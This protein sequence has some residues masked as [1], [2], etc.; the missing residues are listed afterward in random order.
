MEVRGDHRI[1]IKGLDNYTVEEDEGLFVLDS[2]SDGIVNRN[3]YIYMLLCSFFN[4]VTSF[5]Y[6]NLKQTHI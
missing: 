5:L 2:D 4:A 1:N 3:Y 6:L